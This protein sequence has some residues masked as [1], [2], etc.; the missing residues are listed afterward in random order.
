[1]I[2]AH[3]A[4][5]ESMQRQISRLIARHSFAFLVS[6]RMLPAMRPDELAQ[7]PA[8]DHPLVRQHADGRRSLYLSPPYMERIL[9]W[10]ESDSRAL[11]EELSDWAAQE[12]FTYRHRWRPHDLIIWDNGWT[13]HTVSPY[14]LAHRRRRLH[15]TT[16]LGTEQIQPVPRSR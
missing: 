16:I 4:L 3:E 13:M 15:G 8:V 1:M 12:R 9:G 5:P 11:I 14:D 10:N 6:S 7:L 2:A